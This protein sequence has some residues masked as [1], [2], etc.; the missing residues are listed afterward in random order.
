MEVGEH[1]ENLD[2]LQIFPGFCFSSGPC[3]SPLCF[4]KSWCS[5]GMCDSEGPLRSPL[6]VF[7]TA[8]VC[9]FRDCQSCLSSC[10]ELSVTFLASLT[11]CYLPWPQALCDVTL[12]PLFGTGTATISDSARG[13]GFFCIL[14]TVKSG[15]CACAGEGASCH[16]PPCPGQTT[17][18]EL[19]WRGDKEGTAG[20]SPRLEGQSPSCS[21][22]KFSGLSWKS[23][24]Q[25]LYAFDCI[26]KW[27]FLTILPSFVV[28]F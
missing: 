27:L 22:P 26:P 28:S 8:N 6:L 16:G 1:T 21:I 20:I 18:P 13:M 25:V 24:L 15:L 2:H 12:S 7:R 10:V 9:R 11:V 3:V 19:G 23:I 4:H 14:L 5:A 17:K